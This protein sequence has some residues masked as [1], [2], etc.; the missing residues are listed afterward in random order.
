MKIESKY[1][2]LALSLLVFVSLALLLIFADGGKETLVDKFERLSGQK[3]TQTESEIKVSDQTGDSQ[4]I[5]LEITSPE[6]G[7]TVSSPYISVKGKTLSGADVFVNDKETKSDSKGNFSVS[8][9]LDEGEN[10]IVVIV[11]DAGGNFIEREVEVTL[12]SF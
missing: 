1:F 7:S 8:L 6:D 2:L 12:E 4:E 3:V 9:V 10:L 11:N 5:F